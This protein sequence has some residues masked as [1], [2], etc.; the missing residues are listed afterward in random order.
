MRKK[1]TDR[2]NDTGSM[3]LAVFHA[4]YRFLHRDKQLDEERERERRID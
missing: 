1:T 4:R 2:S 3:E